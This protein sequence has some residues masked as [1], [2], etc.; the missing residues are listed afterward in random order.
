MY[1]ADNRSHE[2]QMIN[3]FLA[4]ASVDSTVRIWRRHSNYSPEC[5]EAKF[6]QDQVITSKMNGF[7]LALKFYI[8]PLSNCKQPT[9]SNYFFFLIL[10]NS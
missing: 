10:K 4:S 1:Y 8:L 9:V 6:V 5:G 7:A 2:S 3:T